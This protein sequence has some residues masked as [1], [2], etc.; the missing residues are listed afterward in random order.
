MLGWAVVFALLAIIAGG[1]GFFALAGL[2]AAVAKLLF[3]VFLALLVLSFIVRA[4][5]GD[6]VV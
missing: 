6:S 1:M 5:R 4:I 2:S 3:F